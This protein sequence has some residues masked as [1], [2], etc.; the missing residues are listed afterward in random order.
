L[1]DLKDSHNIIYKLHPSKLRF[2]L[3]NIETTRFSQEGSTKL[4]GTP[5]TDIKWKVQVLSL[6]RGGI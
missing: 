3:Q 1:A 5:L 6:I 4:K 2:Q